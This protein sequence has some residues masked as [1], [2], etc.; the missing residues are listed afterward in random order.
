[1]LRAA[2]IQLLLCTAAIAQVTQAPPQSPASP[3]KPGEASKPTTPTMPTTPTKPA[4]STKQPTTTP[5]NPSAMVQAPTYQIEAW[6][7]FRS[8]EGNFSVTLPI[9]PKGE[10]KRFGLPGGIAEEH[11]YTV[12]THEGNYQVAYTYLSENLATP[13]LVRQRFQFLMSSLK[14]NPDLT[15][16][17]GADIDYDGSPGIE[18]IVESAQGRVQTRSRQYFSYGCIYE[19]T[20]RFLKKQP[21]L[22]E[23]D[24]F[25]ESLKILGPPPARPNYLVPVQQEFPDYTPLAQNRFS[26]TA[27]TL[28]G[29]AVERP[30]PKFKR[31]PNL[32]LGGRKVT[33]LLSISE[34]GKVLRAEA[35]D[36]PEQYLKEAAKTAKK[37]TF[38]PFV[39][40][41]KPVSVEGRLHFSLE[42]E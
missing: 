33:V 12:Q 10:M 7:T 24:L 6:K 35:I 14:K 34:E 21:P 5:P 31:D 27:A 3:N 11:R 13:E 29:H 26:V 32:R 37:W 17:K 8:H 42:F 38:T 4:T 41:G 39:R 2:G 30:D 28:I 15:W 36:G 18:F 9:V 40:D 16:I 20:A 25:I 23:P 22:R 1:M 19:V